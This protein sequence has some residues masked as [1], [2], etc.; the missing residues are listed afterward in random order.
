MLFFKN[1]IKFGNIYACT[2]G[3]HAGKM[4]VYIESNSSQ[5]GFLAIPVM[6]NLWVPKDEF[7]FGLTNDIL[8]FVENAPK[9]V[10]KT[11]K[12]QFIHN[13]EVVRSSE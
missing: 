13:K 9:P 11:S 12:A 6:E 10:K 2:T 3:K 5:H 4:L 8:E 1:K 7:D